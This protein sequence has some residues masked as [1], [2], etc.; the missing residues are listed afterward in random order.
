M[1]LETICQKAIPIKGSEGLI[2]L[3]IYFYMCSIN[4]CRCVLYA[5]KDKC[6]I[7]KYFGGKK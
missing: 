3:K 1:K 2:N 5:E 4:Q 7:L 6:S